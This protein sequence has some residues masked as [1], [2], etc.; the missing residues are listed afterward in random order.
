[1]DHASKPTTQEH[2]DA[3]ATGDLGTPMDLAIRRLV[4]SGRH[5]EILTLF[6]NRIS[7][8]TIQHWRRGRAGIPE[9]AIHCLREHVAPV[10]EIEAGPGR[11]KN[12][13]PWTEM[14]RQRKA[15]KEASG[16]TEM[17]PEH[18]TKRS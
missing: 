1:M 6:G 8:G 3:D 4:P 13:I 2:P 18:K 12:L 14:R 11:G 5:A 9:W 16:W 7:W 15:Q 17:R 10:F